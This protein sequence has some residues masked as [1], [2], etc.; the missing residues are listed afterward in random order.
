MGSSGETLKPSEVD[1]NWDHLYPSFRDKLRKVFDT[2]LAETGTHWVMTEGLR[3]RERQLWLYG[4]GRPDFQPYGRPGSIVTWMKTPVNHGA[5]LAADC[6][7]TKD[8][9]VNFNAPK[10][11]FVRF[12]QVYLKEGLSN[13]AWV[14]GDFGHVQLEDAEMHDRAVYWVDHGFPVVEPYTD[15][16]VWVRNTV[17]AGLQQGATTYA[18]IR[19]VCEA[20]GASFEYL[21]ED[22]C[23]VN[24]TQV[25]MMIVGGTGYVKSSLIR[26]AAQVRVVWDDRTRRVLI[27]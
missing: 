19:A 13:P 16:H 5:G 6:Y 23:E 14:K 8:G 17:L 27:G 20:L 15:V 1:D 25:E 21:R 9:A 22:L 7:P 10:N 26:E 11:V 24:K 3:S 12:R 2:M 18:P 4:Q